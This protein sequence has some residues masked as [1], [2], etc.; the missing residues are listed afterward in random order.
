M[1]PVVS[2]PVRQGVLD[3]P[4]TA[5]D[6]EKAPLVRGLEALQPKLQ[7]RHGDEKGGVI[8][9]V[10]HG[11]GLLGRGPWTLPIGTA[12]E[13]EPLEVD[14]GRVPYLTAARGEQKGE[15]DREHSTAHPQM[16]AGPTTRW[17]ST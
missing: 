14:L 13:G 9:E 1:S 15:Q 8:G 11:S 12:L 17:A 4:E 10:G 6:G 2:G 16:M 3:G 5:L 7:P